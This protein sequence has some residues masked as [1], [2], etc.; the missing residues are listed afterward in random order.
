MAITLSILLTLLVARDVGA[1]ES[2]RGKIS[3]GAVKKSL[4]LPWQIL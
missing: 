2:G 4:T 1:Q 3:S